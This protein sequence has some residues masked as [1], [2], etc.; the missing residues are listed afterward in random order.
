MLKLSLR[1]K[2][3]LKGRSLVCQVKVEVEG[4]LIEMLVMIVSC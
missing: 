2:Q 4:K 1:T 3:A